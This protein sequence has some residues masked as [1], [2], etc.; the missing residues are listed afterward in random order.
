[1]QLRRL[2]LRVTQ[3]EAVWLLQRISW[4]EVRSWIEWVMEGNVS[5]RPAFSSC[6]LH[7]LVGDFDRICML[8]QP[9][10]CVGAVKATIANWYLIREH[11]LIMRLAVSIEVRRWFQR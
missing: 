11:A 4:R 5:R 10:G 7:P 9:L 1:M 8:I 3:Y 6:L 2:F